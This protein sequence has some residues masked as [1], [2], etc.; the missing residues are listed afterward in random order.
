MGGDKRGVTYACRL[1]S[2][3]PCRANHPQ[4]PALPSHELEHA[5]LAALSRR[6][7][8]PAEHATRAKALIEGAAGASFSEAARRIGAFAERVR[9]EKG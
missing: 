4:P 8:Q 6:R 2:L 9:E 3:R 5:A 1:H 7:S